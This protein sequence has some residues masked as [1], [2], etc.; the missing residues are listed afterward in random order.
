M[1][2]NKRKSSPLRSAALELL[3][4]P[5][6]LFQVSQ[7]IGDL[8]V[9]GEYKNRLVLFLAGLTRVFRRPVSVLLKGHPSTGKNNLV[10]AV[11]AVFPQEDVLP[12]SSLTKK[13]PAY[14][15]GKLSGKILYLFQYE[16]GKDAQLL[17]RLLQSE[18]VLEH[19]YTD[20]SAAK[21]RTRV[22]RRKGAPV[23]LTTTTSE[24][25]YIDD[26]TR[27]LS[28]RADD[29]EALTRNVMR[30]VLGCNNV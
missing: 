22:V 11:V 17:I 18:G 27:F 15:K 6:F 3:R 10:G 8:G 28:I 1:K 5:G 21:K 14:G 16:G 29:S 25:V 12:R 23:I 2:K 13:A 4:E 19:E 9:I 20:I 24:Q 26:E 30:A 7:A